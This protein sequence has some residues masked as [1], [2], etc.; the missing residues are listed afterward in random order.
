MNDSRPTPVDPKVI[1][2]GIFQRAQVEHARKIPDE[3][4]AR[5]ALV[6]PENMTEIRKN[7]GSGPE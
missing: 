4:L 7:H 2:D 6:I 1:A 5:E 3:E